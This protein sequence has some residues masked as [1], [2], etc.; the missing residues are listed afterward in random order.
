M[1]SVR[2]WRN[3]ALGWCWELAHGQRAVS[4]SGHATVERA[5]RALTEALNDALAFDAQAAALTAGDRAAWDRN[6]L[7]DDDPEEE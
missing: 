2:V 1:Y 3:A 5:S 6:S 7:F 4:G